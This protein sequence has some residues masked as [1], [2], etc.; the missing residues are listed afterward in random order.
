MQDAGSRPLNKYRLEACQD[1]ALDSAA[2]M[3]M[4]R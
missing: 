4:H 2:G 1:R 3:V